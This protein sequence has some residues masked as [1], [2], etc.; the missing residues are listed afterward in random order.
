MIPAYPVSPLVGM[1]GIGKSNNWLRF[2]ALPVW[3]P[4]ATDI[5][6]VSSSLGTGHRGQLAAV[7]S[8]PGLS[9]PEP[10]DTA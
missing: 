5:S 8:G 2:R 4:Q 7:A 9:A 3:P 6:P 1:A 10:S